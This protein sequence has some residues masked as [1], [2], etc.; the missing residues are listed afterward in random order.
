MLFV[1]PADDEKY[2]VD[3]RLV[4]RRGIYKDVYGSGAGREWSDYQLRANYRW[5]SSLHRFI[6]AR[7]LILLLPVA[8][9]SR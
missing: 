6:R 4:N 5:F 2:N 1:D 7:E 3:S 9:P 8:Q